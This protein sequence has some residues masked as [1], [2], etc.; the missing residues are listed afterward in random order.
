REANLDLQQV[1]SRLGVRAVLTGSVRQVGEDLAIRFD[2]VDANDDRHIA[3]GD[4][5]QKADNILRIQNEIAQAAFEKLRLKLTDSQ[6]KR[7]GRNDTENS[8]AYRYY[9]SG[10]VE[11]N[12][13]QDVR[14][15][16]LEYFEQ[17]VALDPDFAAALAEIGWIYVVRATA[18]D[19][20]H[21]LIP[22]A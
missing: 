3:G 12:G 17:A 6:S 20:P 10:L 9:L 13:P 22:K 19:N 5:R 8:A 14:S 2:I 21:E 7:F 15:K 11:L 1:A 4:Y 18:S 16:A